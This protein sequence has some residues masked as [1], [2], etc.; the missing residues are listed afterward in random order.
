LSLA[1]AFA[2]AMARLRRI[3]V[4]GL[5]MHVIHRGANRA[6]VFRDDADYELFLEFLREAADRNDTE[7][8]AATLM[9]NH[10][11]LMVTPHHESSLPR[12]MKQVGGW[13]V[14][15]VNRRYGRFGTLWQGRYRAIPIDTDRYW[16]TCL[17][18][19]EQNPVRAGMV[20]SAAHYPWSTYQAHA[21]GRW[22]RWLVPHPVYLALGRAAGEREACY[23]ALCAEPL[24]DPELSALRYAVH[25]GWAYG[26]RAFAQEVEFVCGRPATPRRSRRSAR[27][28]SAITSG[29]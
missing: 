10:V 1:F 4:P 23:R 19:I 21:H 8:H 28:L 24:P 6:D 3:F 29:V 18:Y 15:Y 17:R 11:H 22:P 27:R 26:S 13:Y 5:T 9:T 25:H 16:L 20:A 7:V 12:T 14:P 2:Y